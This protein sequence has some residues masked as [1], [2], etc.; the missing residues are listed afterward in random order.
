MYDNEDKKWL[1]GKFS[2][3]GLNIGS[4]EDFEK[5][6]QNDDDKKWYHEKATSMGLNVGS[7][8]DFNSLFGVPA[9]P[10]TNQV[11]NVTAQRNRDFAHQ[12]EYAQDK[13]VDPRLSDSEKR[14][15]VD[16]VG[17]YADR[18]EQIRGQYGRTEAPAPETQQTFRAG[19]RYESQANGDLPQLLK[20]AGLTAKDVSFD[21]K[22]YR[23]VK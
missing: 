22:K 16:F 5:S 21:G 15:Y 23:E 19:Q 8:D 11:D 1:Y 2:D 14:Q 3:A 18:Y 4:Y 13:V 10:Q 9:A 12:Y 7:Y 20:D 6:L 17:N